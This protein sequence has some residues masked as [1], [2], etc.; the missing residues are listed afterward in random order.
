M[1]FN[2]QKP[3][4]FSDLV[5][6]AKPQEEPAVEVQEQVIANIQVDENDLPAFNSMA[7]LMKSI[8]DQGEA[9][10]V[11]SEPDFVANPQA[12]VEE[13]AIEE[14]EVDSDEIEFDPTN[15]DNYAPDFANSLADLGFIEEL[16]DGVKADNFTFED[17]KSTIEHNLK[18]REEKVYHD[19]AKAYHENLTRKIP[20]KVRDFVDFC[21]SNA[22]VTDEDAMEYFGQLDYTSQ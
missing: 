13:P 16:P 2:F 14:V 3:V 6:G 10:P 7:D 4:D 12:S 19:G 20:N 15:L 9:K 5:F 11:T 1:E 22:N 17:F 21:L 8:E 18:K